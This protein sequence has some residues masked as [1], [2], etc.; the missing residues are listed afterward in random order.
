MRVITSV[1]VV[2]RSFTSGGI[3]NSGSSSSCSSSNIGSSSRNS[4]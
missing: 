3:I 4:E 2:S 1:L